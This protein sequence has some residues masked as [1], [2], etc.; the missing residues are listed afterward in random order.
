M[1]NVLAVA[2]VIDV[3]LATS[4]AANADS[5]TFTQIDVP[6]AST[7]AFGINDAGQ[8]V[9]LFSNSTGTHGFLA[10]PIPVPEPGTLTLTLLG[11][12]ALGVFQSRK[13]RATTK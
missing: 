12:G 9:G 11:V 5:Y 8:I 3:L 6:G 1:R 2:A 7:D 13:R 10:T 4:A